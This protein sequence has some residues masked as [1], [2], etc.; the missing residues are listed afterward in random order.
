[1]AGHLRDGLIV[2]L[3]KRGNPGK[4]KEDAG[5][6]ARGPPVVRLTIPAR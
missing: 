3:R 6:T 4:A 2:G 5:G 1:M